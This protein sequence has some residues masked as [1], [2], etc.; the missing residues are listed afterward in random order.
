[1]IYIQEILQDLGIQMQDISGEVK[2]LILGS[3]GAYV[4]GFQKIELMQE[5]KICVKKKNVTYVLEGNHLQIKSLS[6]TE[7]HIL[8][9]VT[10]WRKEV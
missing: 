1:M 8:G 9:E 2:C 10:A 7:M 5:D 6:K 3:Y 4:Q